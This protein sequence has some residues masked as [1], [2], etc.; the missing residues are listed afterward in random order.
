MAIGTAGEDLMQ[1]AENAERGR[2]DY[3]D[4]RLHVRF[5]I[6]PF[7]KEE[8]S[9]K[10]GRPIYEDTEFIEIMVPGDKDNIVVDRVNN[11]HRRRFRTRYERWKQDGTGEITRGT[12]LREWPGCTRSQAEEFAFFG[13]K[14]VEQLAEMSDGNA[15]KFMGS[16]VLRQKARDFL[17]AAKDAEHLTKMRTEMEQV[18]SENEGLKAMMAELKE[19]VGELR[20]KSGK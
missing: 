11:I 3:A 10:E 16:M 5:F 14:T 13:V 4:D 18:R 20:R 7:L 2:V 17:A 8:D 6:A 15:Q 12:S 1:M 19:Q 9:K